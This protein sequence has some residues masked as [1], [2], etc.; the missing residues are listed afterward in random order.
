MNKAISL[1]SAIICLFVIWGASSS[2]WPKLAALTA[3]LWAINAWHYWRR[4]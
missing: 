4:Q 2:G 3:A 1:F